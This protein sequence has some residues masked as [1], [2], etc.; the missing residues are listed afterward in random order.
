MMSILGLTV[1]LM[2]L[3]YGLKYFK[4]RMLSNEQANGGADPTDSQ[5]SSD[6]SQLSSEGAA[7][8]DAWKNRLSH[9]GP[10]SDVQVDLNTISSQQ[11]NVEIQEQKLDLLQQGEVQEEDLDFQSHDLQTLAMLFNNKEIQNIAG[12]DNQQMAQLQFEDEKIRQSE[13]MTISDISNFSDFFRSSETTIEADDTSV[14]NLAKQ[15][16]TQFSSQQQQ[17]QL[18]DEKAENIALEEYNEEVEAEKHVEDGLGEEP[19][20]VSNP[21]DEPVR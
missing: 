21:V 10:G 6:R 3:A 8:V 15:E 12:L 18:V 13:T 16:A 7:E 1:G 14:N 4:G 17:Q 5:L 2:L 11:D 9:L 19:D 20:K